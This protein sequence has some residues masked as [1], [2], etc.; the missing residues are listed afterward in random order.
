MAEPCTPEQRDLVFN[1]L[2][3]KTVD[4]R[5]HFVTVSLLYGIAC[6]WAQ[7]QGGYPMLNGSA[8]C[9]AMKRAGYKVANVEGKPFAVLDIDLTP[10]R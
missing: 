9:A 5:Q 6:R 3:V 8:F 10:R 1:F 4:R 7:E 2:R